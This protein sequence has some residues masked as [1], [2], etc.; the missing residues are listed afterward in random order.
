MD[1]EQQQR[2]AVL[3]QGEETDVLIH[4]W[5]EQVDWVHVYAMSESKDLVNAVEASMKSF[6]N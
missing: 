5:R 1:E 2:V 4:I 6:A 3:F